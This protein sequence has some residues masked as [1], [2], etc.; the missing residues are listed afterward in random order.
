MKLAGH[1]E[2][3]RPEKN[4]GYRTGGLI[5]WGYESRFPGASVT[6]VVGHVGY[7]L[8]SESKAEEVLPRGK[9][10]ASSI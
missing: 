6:G 8:P 4:A 7:F 5:K 9:D 1:T 2:S 10:Q 3:P